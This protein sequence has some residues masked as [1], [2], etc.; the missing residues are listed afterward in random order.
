MSNQ[1]PP[2]TPNLPIRLGCPV[3]SCGDWADVVYPA[4]TPKREYLNWYSQMFNCVEGNSSFYAI[5][6]P[7]LAGRWARESA[8]GFQFC[9][10]FPRSIS[11]ERQLVSAKQETKHFL[12][13]I[14]TLA[15]QNR[16]GTTFLQLGPDFDPSRFAALREYLRNLPTEF[17][18][19]V[20]VRHLDWFDQGENEKRLNSLLT[21]LNIDRCLFDSRPLFQAAASDEIER[22][23]QSRKPKSPVRQTVTSDCP[24]L[25]IV[26][27]NQ[28]ELTQK[29]VDQWA[30]IVSGWINDGLQPTI[31]THAPDDRF[32]PAFARLFYEALAKASDAE[33]SETWA[34]IPRLPKKPRQLDLL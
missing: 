13:A 5:P 29:Y 30:T 14:E 26:G 33:T 11:H 4:K 1:S 31:F 34:K 8:D 25:R 18:W 3:W 20:E 23:S 24:M 21:D 17:R 28:V 6:S 10:K 22:I 32:A 16:L 9:L 27:R 12:E 15:N 7:E 2:T 19:A